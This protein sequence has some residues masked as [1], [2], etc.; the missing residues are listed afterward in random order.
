MW[1][2][3]TGDQIEAGLIVGQSFGGMLAGFDFQTALTGG[4]VYPVKHGLGEIGAN[5][6]VSKAGAVKAGVTGTGGD[7]QH[8]GG[9]VQRDALQRGRHISYVGQD[10][11]LCVKMALPAELLG[12]GTLDSVEVHNF[13]AAMFFN[14]AS[15][16]AW[17]NS[18]ALIGQSISTTGND[19]FRCC[20]SAWKK[21]SSAKGS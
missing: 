18:G 17:A 3:A 15:A 11:P 8:T 20:F 1:S 6:F 13:F 12:G 10:M 7:I 5:D 14:N 2:Y 19:F 9:R 16:H 21:A 4:F